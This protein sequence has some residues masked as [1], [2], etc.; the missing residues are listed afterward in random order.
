M[1]LQE[2][3]EHNRRVPSP[4]YSSHASRGEKSANSGSCQEGYAHSPVG[5][6]PARPTRIRQSH[7]PLLNGLETE[8]FVHIKDQYPNYPPVR[9]QAKRYKIAGGSWYKPDFTCSLWPDNYGDN[10]Q[11][12]ETAWEIKGGKKMKGVPKGILALKVAAH[13]WP[14]VRFVLV[15]KQ[16]GKFQ[17]QTVVP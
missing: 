2:V 14:E 7:K 4:G 5:S 11:A 16:D 15:W 3:L 13:Q 9:A 10:G 8:W 17:T 12:K 1:K 6:N